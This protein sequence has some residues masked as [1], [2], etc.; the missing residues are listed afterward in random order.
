MKRNIVCSLWLCC[1]L[2]NACTS[3]QTTQTAPA[4]G[5]SVVI[6]LPQYGHLRQHFSLAAHTMYRQKSIVTAP[7]PA[8]I[9]ES[10]I[11]PG[12]RVNAGQIIFRLQTRERRALTEPDTP[13][14]TTAG[15]IPLTATQSGIILDVLQQP[16][17]YVPEGTILCT[18]ADTSSLVFVIHVPYELSQ[19]TRPG[20][21]CLL[22][23]PNDRQLRA[24]IRSTLA[25]MDRDSQSEQVIATAKAP[26]LPEGMQLNALIPIRQ[27][28]DRPN[29]ILPKNAIQTDDT[30]TH[31]WVM[32]LA[33][34]TTAV[35]QPVEVVASNATQV[36]I[37]P[38][39]LSPQDRIIVLG[40]YG[41]Q[42]GDKVKVTNL[43][44]ETE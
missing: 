32:K 16:G 22:Q 2:A 19:Y 12:T 17:S 34:D 39:A 10:H 18:I 1:L 14:T 42:D 25:T 33:N 7:I 30:M 44:K 13:Q 31:Y 28:A 41:L 37:R 29:I 9:T 27:T 26:F 35:K 5:T 15:T 36:E 11:L 6:T 4:P 38:A 43:Q 3:T 24:T 21:D 40:G 23:L 20:A 8:F